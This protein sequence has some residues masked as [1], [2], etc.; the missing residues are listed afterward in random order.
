MKAEA[1]L[2][3]SPFAPGAWRAVGAESKAREN[4][5]CCFEEQRSG[6]VL[7]VLGALGFT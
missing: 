1:E 2:F 3:K 4:P 5:R 7:G 6:S